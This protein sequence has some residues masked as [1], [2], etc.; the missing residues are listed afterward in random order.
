MLADFLGWWSA[1][2]RGLH[3]DESVALDDIQIKQQSRA[4]RLPHHGLHGARMNDDPEDLGSSMDH[5]VDR[6]GGPHPQNRSW[7]CQGTLSDLK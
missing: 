4:C 1:Y 5:P 7:C 6:R 3:P 2:H